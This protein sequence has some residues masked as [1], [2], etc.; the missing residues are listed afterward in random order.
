MKQFVRKI[1]FAFLIII[2]LETFVFNYRCW[3]SLLNQ[4]KVVENFE[5]GKGIKK[6]GEYYEIVDEKEAFLEIKAL[7]INLKNILADIDVADNASVCDERFF[8]IR[9]FM[10][11][12]ANSEYKELPSMNIV[13]RIKESKYVRL[14]LSGKTNKIKI[15]IDLP[16]GAKISVNKIAFNV[17]RPFIVHP[18]RIVIEMIIF[19]LFEIFRPN[20]KVYNISLNIKKRKQ[21]IFI[22][23]ALGLNLL[24]LAGISISTFPTR[25]LG[26]GGWLPDTEYEELTD[27]LIDGHF[28][29]NIEPTKALEN[30]DNPYDPQLRSKALAETGETYYVDHAY[31]KGKYYCYFGIVPALIFF[32]PF[33][34]LFGV[35]LSTWIAVTFCGLMYCIV[36]YIFIYLIIKKYYKNISF[37]TYIVTDTIFIAMSAIV[38]LVFYGTIYSLPIMMSLMLGIIGL[39]F[40]IA[41]SDSKKLNK[42]YLILGSLA[43]ALII[44]CRP[45]LAIILLFAFPIFWND[46]K[47]KRFF[48]VK[49]MANTLSVIVPFLII[50]V[51]IMYYNYARFGSVMDFG[52]NYNLTSN[53]MT[54]R[55]IVLARN[56][57]GIFEYIFQ[58]LNI[59]SKFPFMQLIGNNVQ[60]DYQG[61]L[62]QEPLFGG[63]LW[64]NPIL[65]ICWAYFKGRKEMKKKKCYALGV[66]AFVSAVIIILLTIQMSG[67]TQRYM[68]DFG[69]L[70]AMSTVIA[71]LY[72][73]EKYRNTQK[74]YIVMKVLISLSAITLVANYF[75]IFIADRYQNL[76]YTNPNLW[77]WVKY[78]LFSI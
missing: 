52:A 6:S 60:F 71:F 26:N 8:P 9:I 35:H 37:G 14:H 55:G 11:D 20:S 33:K 61:Y 49:G 63:F 15:K 12:E 54:H 76:F 21:R 25:N 27:A 42:I 47:E 16:E 7:N 72:L 19:I 67:M 39:S 46:I 23:L 51:G 68:S 78:A 2:G 45:Q 74:Y 48:S 65:V 29:L 56:W 30:I 75:N 18:L 77:F 31:Y 5:C 36:S 62:S 34:L 38:Y 58:P 24:V 10:T 17:K 22:A 28:Y 13:R 50:G 73:E 40:W 43:I 53:D 57:V 64:F 41:A 69:W 3:E 59:S 1:L 66:G 44:G 70:F 4:E 32:V